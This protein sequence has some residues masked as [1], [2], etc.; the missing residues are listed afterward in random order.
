MNSQRSRSI[1]TSSAKPNLPKHVRIHFDKVRKATAILAPES[2][3]WPN[4]VS[5]EILRRCDGRS[6]VE[7]IISDLTALY[8]ADQ[9]LVSRDV[10]EFLEEWSDKLLVKL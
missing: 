5:L 7:E 10:K 3:L 4:E 6:T 9:K 2:V 1:I 8:Q